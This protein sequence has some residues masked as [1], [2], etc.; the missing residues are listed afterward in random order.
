[1]FN[2]KYSND[3]LVNCVECNTVFVVGEAY[4][5]TPIKTYQFTRW[6]FEVGYVH[7]TIDRGHWRNLPVTGKNKAEKKSDSIIV[8]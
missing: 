8:M 1:M 3:H 6:C 2:C 4:N 5:P 7:E